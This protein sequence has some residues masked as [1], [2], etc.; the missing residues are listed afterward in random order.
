VV[1]CDGDGRD[2]LVLHFPTEDTGFDGDEGTGRLEG[3]TNDGTS[4]FGTDSVKLVGQ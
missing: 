4:L 1:P 2:D 3:E